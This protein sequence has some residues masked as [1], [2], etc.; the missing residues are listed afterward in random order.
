MKDGAYNKIT[1]SLKMLYDWNLRNYNG[2]DTYLDSALWM[3]QKNYLFIYG[4]N[5]LLKAILG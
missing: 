1:Q 4:D 2:S 3:L 5:S